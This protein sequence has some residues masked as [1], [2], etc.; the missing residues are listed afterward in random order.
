M[1][2][3]PI[4]G[5]GWIVAGILFF[6]LVLKDILQEKLTQFGK[7]VWDWT[8]QRMAGN[9]LF[10]NLALQ[11]YQQ[12]L[13]D[14]LNILYTPF[15]INPPLAMAEVYVPLKIKEI[16]AE[17]APGQQHRH[18]SRGSELDIYEAMVHHKRLMVTG[19]PGSGEVGV[20]QTHCLYLR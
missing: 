4:G 9:P 13:Q 5:F 11:K 18:L 7:I 15:K 17:A 12:T 10:R 1:K 8:Y 19:P 2:H 16:S 3:F 6:L 14:R 20:A